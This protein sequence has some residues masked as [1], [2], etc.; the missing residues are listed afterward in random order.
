MSRYWC[1]PCLTATPM[2]LELDKLQT[3]CDNLVMR[4]CSVTQVGLG[5][6][7]MMLAHSYSLPA[8]SL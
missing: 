7:N 2:V 1:L 4:V 5:P 8:N 6:E 3:H